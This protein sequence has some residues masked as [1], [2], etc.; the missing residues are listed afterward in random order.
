MDTAQTSQASQTETRTDTGRARPTRKEFKH[1][2]V[3]GSNGALINEKLVAEKLT[4]TEP[5]LRRR[6]LRENGWTQVQV[7]D[8]KAYQDAF[9]DYR[10]SNKQT[11]TAT[12]SSMLAEA[13][14]NAEQGKNSRV[15]RALTILL[16][17]YS[18]V[19]DRKTVDALKKIVRVVSSTSPNYVEKAKA[20]RVQRSAKAAEA[21]VH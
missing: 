17:L 20:P 16:P 10:A 19:N 15:E 13:F 12:R 3:I 18:G 4:A 7:F 21:A 5:K 11:A 2:M 14:E 6:Q 1:T 8:K 9:V